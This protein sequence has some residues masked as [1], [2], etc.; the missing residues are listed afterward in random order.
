MITNLSEVLKFS[1]TGASESDA[2]VVAD[3]MSDLS[4]ASSWTFDKESRSWI[5]EV[6]FEKD[7]LVTVQQH[8]M[9][10]N[11]AFRIALSD[12][13]ISELE[14]R[15]WLKENQESF[16]PIEVG[17]FYIYGSHIQHPDPGS[18]IPLLIDAA[19]AFGSGNHGSTKGCL[20]ALSNLKELG[21][22]PKTVL[23][24]G[25]G[26]GVLAMASAKLWNDSNI[27]ASDIDPECVRVTRENCVNN[28][29]GHIQTFEGDGFKNPEIIK[30]KPFDMI[31]ANILASVLCDISGDIVANIAYGG[32]V[33]L[34]GILDT[35]QNTVLTMYTDLGLRLVKSQQHDEWVTLTLQSNHL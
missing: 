27:T 26:S 10:V 5:V 21:F 35:Q 17:V 8:L 15:D 28:H 14:D 18:R 2:S 22:V 6:L 29:V 34:S 25:C 16:Q 31:I 4:L 7:D 1:C 23:D 13:D 12:A 11:T 24:V 33:I 9:L 32:Y 30:H 19:T 3:L 20:E